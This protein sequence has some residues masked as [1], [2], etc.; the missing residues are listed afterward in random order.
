MTRPKKPKAGPRGR[1]KRYY[2]SISAEAFARI[3]R[4]ADLLGMALQDVAEMALRDV[5]V[6]CEEQN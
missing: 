3:Q 5:G 6:V 2:V 4:R 1:A